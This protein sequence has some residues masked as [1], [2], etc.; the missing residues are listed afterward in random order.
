MHEAPW[1][2]AEKILAWNKRYAAEAAEARRQREARDEGTGP[3][4]TNAQKADAADAEPAK[5]HA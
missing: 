2:L 3:R 1:D 4:K 5:E